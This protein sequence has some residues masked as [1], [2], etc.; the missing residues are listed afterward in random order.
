MSDMTD[1]ALEPEPESG[2]RQLPGDI[3]AWIF[4]FA[5]LAVFGIMFIGFAVARSLDPATFHAGREVLHPLIGLLNTA[6]LITASYL[7]AT[8]VHQLRHRR[9]GVQWR[10]WLAVAVSCIYTVGKVYEYV[11]LYSQGYNLGTDTFFM[12]YFFLTFF[13]FMHVILGQ[14]ILIVLAVKVG[15]GDYDGSDMNGME[16][17]ASYWHMVDLVWLVLFPMIYVLA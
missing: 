17:G 16:S 8:S 6:A 11:N 3:A 15:N 1:L 4:I 12:F 14:V 2:A 13:H 10:L 9:S 5:E 7:V